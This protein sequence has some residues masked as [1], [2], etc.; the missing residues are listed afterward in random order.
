ML[1]LVAGGSAFSSALLGLSWARAS[2]DSSKAR[3]GRRVIE[4]QGPAAARAL[5][6]EAPRSFAPANLDRRIADDFRAGR[7]VAVSGVLFSRT[8]AAMF[9]LAARTDGQGLA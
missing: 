4:E 7:T 9:V 2:V 1:A 8:E 3:L 6:A 5:L